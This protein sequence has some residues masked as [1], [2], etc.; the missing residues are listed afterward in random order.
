MNF[1]LVQALN[2]MKRWAIAL[3]LPKLTTSISYM[4]EVNK[5]QLIAGKWAQNE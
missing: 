2:M 1:W 3:R 4:Q 5:F